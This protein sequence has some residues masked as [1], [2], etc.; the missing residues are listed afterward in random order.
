MGSDRDSESFTADYGN[1]LL[2]VSR[3]TKEQEHVF[4]YT[5]MDRIDGLICWNG[6]ASDLATAQSDAVLEAQ[7]F[8]DPYIS[9]PPAPV[10][11]RG[12]ETATQ[13]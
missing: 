9:S 4:G 5:V 12:G 11:R 3:N 1:L 7:L 2:E 13:I 6:S 8:L 10:W